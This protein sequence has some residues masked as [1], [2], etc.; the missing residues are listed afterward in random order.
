M[1]FDVTSRE[2]R[3]MLTTKVRIWNTLIDEVINCTR[4]M[5]VKDDKN[6]SEAVCHIMDY[7][8][9]VKV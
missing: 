2:L 7:P 6:L 3:D 4:C 9:S 8:S 5:S 1:S